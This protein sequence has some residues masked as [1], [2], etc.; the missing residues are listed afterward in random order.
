[1]QELLTGHACDA[2]R[3]FFLGAAMLFAVAAMS[4]AADSPVDF[5]RDIQP[6][7]SEHCLKCHG[8][9]KQKGGLRFDIKDGAVRKGDSGEAAIVVGKAAGSS[10]MRRV[11]TK[12]ADERMPPKGEGLSAK[13]VDLLRRWIDRGATWPDAA[14]GAVVRREMVVT[15]EDR[16]HWSFLPLK[17]VEPP[18]V[19]GDWARAPIDQ[20]ILASMQSAKPRAL[21][22]SQSLDVRR[23]IR[24]VYFDI[25]GLPP[26]PEEV[27]AFAKDF[28]WQK[29]EALIDRLLASQH[30]GERWARH[31]LDVARYADS[32][33]QE[34]DQD[35]PTAYHYRDFVIRALNDDLP[36]DTFVR[37]Q[38]AGDEIDPD[39]P[40]ALAATG[41][42]TAGPHTV[43]ADSFLE[44]ERLQNKY[45]ELDD[46]IATIGS[47]M[48][49]LTVACARCHDHKYDSIPARDYYRMLAA[50]HTGDRAEVPLASR[51]QIK[52]Y[53]DAH[54]DWDKGR[55]TVEE[56]LSRWLD[57]KKKSLDATLRPAKID[58]LSISA[59]EK[60]LLREKPDSSDA[61]T[62]A[63]KH[64]KA[65]AISDDEYRK[66][67]TEGERR[68]WAMLQASVAAHREREPKAPPTALAFRDGSDKPAPTWLFRRADFYDRQV[69]VEVG[70]VSA[71]TRGKAP[72]DYWNAAKQDRPLPDSTYQRAAMAH[73][74]TDTQHGAGPLVARVIVNR[75]WQHHFG[76]GL[77][78]SVND[79]GVQGER[80]S[81][82]ELLEWLA[83][84]FVSHGWKLK[85]LHRM[86]L[87]SAVYT[88]DTTFDSA[89]AAIDPENRLLWR[90]RPQR[91]EAEILRDAMLAAA[92][93]LNLD[94][95]GPGFQP[96]VAP[97]AI[98][99]RNLKD[100]Y[101]K[102]LKDGPENH[103][104]T[105][106]MFHKRIVPFPLLQAFDAPD[107]QQ[108][109]GKR[110]NTTV[111]LQALA[112]LNDG[113]VRMRSIEFA[114]RL[115]N[116]AGDTP[117]KL[118]QRGF[119]IA[120][121][122]GPRGSE[123]DAALAF[124][125]AR[126][127]ERKQR[128]AKVT[129]Q[130]SRRQAMADFCQAMFA[131]NEFIYVD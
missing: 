40:L 126:I 64:A 39:N 8:P 122:R 131:L 37:W 4:H 67:M 65:L 96:P 9:E 23:L 5:N 106:Y 53:R 6:L 87:L 20:F 56:Y 97:E 26:T 113:F 63:R 123:R 30:Y 81:H 51:D 57:P 89:K 15:D 117:V 62:L 86:I 45:N 60:H 73:W 127:Q 71:I 111:A 88:Q 70:F 114:D 10:V 116:E 108:S 25:T 43:L 105:V 112:I 107:A 7:L 77:V 100:P 34:G 99:A 93:S 2:V 22:P 32:N 83:H 33:G 36:F 38:L 31:W 128:D 98:V 72:A 129:E 82:P 27:D 12:D 52:A 48:L 21:E 76:E 58:A 110:I 118:V 29:Y 101:P 24:R 119:E 55:K 42:L 85:R 19:R 17:K 75:V 47:A 115:L 46:T 94:P 103:R 68:A 35:R 69:S 109:C 84:D 11:T 125:N 104:R 95:Y 121:G 28:T 90:M 78:R 3:R 59:D 41:F 13:E 74:M 66:A 1:M 91:L 102:N 92:G 124:I 44:E 49:G 18:V 16:E 14:P 79:F 54:A 120:L 61:K 50:F 130:E 80:P